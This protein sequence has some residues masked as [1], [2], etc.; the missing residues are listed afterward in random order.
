[1]QYRIWAEMVANQMHSNTDTPPS[2]SMFKRAGDGG[3]GNSGKRSD[4][5]GMTEAL[6]EFATSIT[7]V[8]TT[9]QEACVSPLKKIESRSKCYK[10]ISDLNNLKVQ[11]F[12]TDEEFASEKQ[13]IIISKF[14]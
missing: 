8:L 5:T 4:S 13:S 2:S 11:G 12:I 6:T 9:P 7:A 14:N 3:G 10:Q 1:M